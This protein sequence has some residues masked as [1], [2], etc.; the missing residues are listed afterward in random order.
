M[1]APRWISGPDLI[2]WNM[3]QTRAI[4]IGRPSC[5]WPNRYLAFN[6][7]HRFKITRPRPNPLPIPPEHGGACNPATVTIAGL[8]TA[9]HGAQSL[10]TLG[11]KW[12]W[13]EGEH[14]ERVL[15]LSPT[16]FQSVHSKPRMRDGGG[17]LDALRSPSCP[18]IATNANRRHGRSLLAARKAP[19]WH[20]ALRTTV[21]H[22]FGAAAG[23]G[24]HGSRRLCSTR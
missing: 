6:R 5:R 20:R 10:N 4:P 14:G 17:K 21:A 24:S 19:I 15:T 7:G 8:P 3:P 1:T 18:A 23:Y 11:A 22:G 13:G 2:Q 16:L 12:N 9:H